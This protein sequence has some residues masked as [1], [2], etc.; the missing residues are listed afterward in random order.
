[1][2]KCQTLVPAG[3]P[4]RMPHCP[5]NWSDEMSAYTPTDFT[6]FIVKSNAKDI[7]P[8][9]WADPT[10]IKDASLFERFNEV[11]SQRRRLSISPED[12]VVTFDG[13]KFRCP[14]PTG[15]TGRGLLGKW[16]PNYAAD[17]LVTRDHKSG[18]QVLLVTRADGSLA[19]PGGMVEHGMNVPTTLRAELT[20][21]AVKDGAIVDKLFTECLKQVVYTGFVDDTRN[22]DNAWMETTV[23]WFHTTPEVAAGLE[24]CTT[25]NNEGILGVDWYT[26]DSL[27]D[28]DMFA[29]HIEWIR[30]V[31]TP[32][33]AD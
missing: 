21:E 30:S 25:D 11:S 29:S 7:N 14:Y 8:R 31:R 15:M 3:Y 33:D 6:S 24:L 2:L 13:T 18:M 32:V 20:E 22:T 4:P 28:E 9:G 26:I 27:K 12:G 10:N 5:R 17:P 23:T 19:L 16:G 1:M